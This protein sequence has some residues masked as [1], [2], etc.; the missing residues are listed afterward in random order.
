MAHTAKVHAY[1][2]S[3]WEEGWSAYKIAKEIG[4]SATTIL[5]WAEDDNWPENGS[6]RKKLEET[7]RQ[8]R[9]EEAKQ[10]GIDKAKWLEEQSLIAFSDIA[11]HVDI[12][13]GGGVQ[14]KTFEEMNECH[15]GASRRIKKIREKRVIRQT[16]DKSEDLILDQTFEFELW[17]KQKSLD[18]IGRH[19]GWFKSEEKE[20]S[21][22]ILD[23]VR[24]D[25]DS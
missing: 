16:N 10:R 21:N 13:E 12:H 2:Q 20:N 15:P 4:S 25:E 5:K 18:T 7:E 17:D 23:S 1:A 3:R 11:D 24:D 6:K 19:M 14:A 8:A 22:S 9:E